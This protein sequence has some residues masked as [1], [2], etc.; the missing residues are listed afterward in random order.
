MLE[1]WGVIVA[2]IFLYANLL[3]WSR[4]RFNESLQTGV[5]FEVKMIFFSQLVGFLK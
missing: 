3:A 1:N 4:Q 5:K 2:W